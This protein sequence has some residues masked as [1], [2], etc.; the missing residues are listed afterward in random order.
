ML[1][2]RAKTR[3]AP[4]G[5]ATKNPHIFSCS[6]CPELPFCASVLKFVAGKAGLFGRKNS[7]FGL[8]RFSVEKQDY[9]DVKT[10]SFLFW[11][12]P[13]LGVH[14]RIHELSKGTDEQKVWETLV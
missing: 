11:S 1:I 2:N 10:F 7:F 9:V 6:V 12:S 4:I 14:E 5:R 3:A 13:V 8:H